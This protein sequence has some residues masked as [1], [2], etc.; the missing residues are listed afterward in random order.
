MAAQQRF[1]WPLDALRLVPADL[2][3]VVLYAVV[4]DLL[5]VFEVVGTNVARIV[6][7]L[8]LLFVLPGYVL[9]AFLFPADRTAPSGIDGTTRAILSVGASLALLAVFG[10][11][12]DLSSYGFDP[13]TVV[14]TV[15][16]AVIVGAVVATGWRLRTPPE[17]RFTVEPTVY[18]DR[19]RNWLIGGRRVDTVINVALAVSVLIAALAVGYAVAVPGPSDEY[20]QFYAVTDDD[21]EPSASEYLADDEPV[22]L[23]IENREGG[24]ETYTVLV[25]HQQLA[26]DGNESSVEDQRELDRLSPTVA[27]GETWTDEYAVEVDGND[28]DERVAFL[29]YRGDPADEPSAENADRSLHLWFDAAAENET[30]EEGVG[31]IG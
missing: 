29:L 24:S 10:I 26:I 4:V 28:T 3:A 21:G 7:G 14:L 17:R 22:T 15:S 11:A 23:G 12:I 18:A 31:P 8:P 16:T 13:R 6:V 19:F 1:A 27:S 20:T 5:F 9:V 30:D 2:L 25:V